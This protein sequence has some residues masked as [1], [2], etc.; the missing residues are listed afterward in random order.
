[1]SQEYFISRLTD[2]DRKAEEQYTIYYSDFLNADELNMFSE[3]K[4]LFHSQYRTFGGNEFSERQM[5]A[6]IPDALIFI[7]EYP[8]RCLKVQGKQEKFAEVL[9]HRDI[10]GALMNLGIERRL[11]GDIMMDGKTAYLFCH[12]RI[13]DFI[14]SELTRIRHT[15]VKITPVELSEASSCVRTET[16][17]I[18]A[19]SNRLDC[20]V[21]GITNCSRKK[22]AELIER[23][24][25]AV[26]SRTTIHNAYLCKPNDLLSIRGYGRAKILENDQTTKKGKFR[27]TY[28]KFL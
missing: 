24:L 1:M 8:I 26:N 23:E 19:A 27:I 2:L 18:T 5:I 12:E 10:L 14:C 13:A 11:L 25:V 21:A 15:A 7:P 20:L 16:C 6:F 4:G 9:S 22:A 3:N 17:S 28:L